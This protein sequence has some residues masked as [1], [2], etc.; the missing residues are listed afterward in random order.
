MWTLHRWPRVRTPG[1]HL[2]SQLSWSIHVHSF[3]PS[4]V[5]LFMQH[6]LGPIPLNNLL[7]LWDF[8]EF[9]HACCEKGACF[10]KGKEE[11]KV[12]AQLFTLQLVLLGQMWTLGEDQHYWL[13]SLFL[14]LNGGRLK[15]CFTVVL[16]K[17][18]AFVYPFK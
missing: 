12:K 11:F 14:S 1:P 18:I 2:P 17:S 9:K 5:L 16:I 15:F 3:I 10:S 7:L 8:A 6:N 13:Y 4:L